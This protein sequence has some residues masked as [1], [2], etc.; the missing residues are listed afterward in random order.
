MASPMRRL[1][2]WWKPVLISALL[3]AVVCLVTSAASRSALMGDLERWGY[4]L[5]VNAGGYAPP[6]E[7]V[8]LV[9]FDD[10]SVAALHTFPVPRGLVAKTLRKVSEG[11]P[12]LI[13]LDML[14][15]EKR[16]PEE[17][18]E[19]A[20][21]LRGAGNVIL[22][23]QLSSGQL[24]LAGPMPEFC[25]PESD[26]KNISYCQ[27]GGAFGYASINMPVDDDGFIR[28]M[29]L[30]PPRGVSALPFPVAL[31]RDFRRLSLQAG[32][33]GV[34]RLG[35]HEIRLDDSGLNAALIGAWN[36]RPA[37]TVPAAAVLAPGFDPGV[38]KGKLV[39]I[40]QS[41]AAGADRHFTPVFRPR[42]QDGSRV[43]LSG[44]EIH[45]A[46]IATLLDARAVRVIDQ[47][48]LWAANFLAGL[49][50][51]V[52]IIVLRPV[53]SAPL[54][55]A[56][57]LGAYAAAQHL[58]SSHQAWMKFGTT[59]ATLLLALPAGLGYRFV[60]ERWLKSQAEAERQQ[61][62]GI[63]SRYVS[64]EVAAE[65]WE[66]RGEIVLGGQEKTAT[67]L[68]SDIRS[69]TALTAGKPSAEVLGWL[70]DYFTAMAE[71]IREQGGFLNK[72]IGD[73][74]MAV[75]GVPLSNGAQDDACRAVETALRMTARVE[76]LNREHE[77]DPRYPRIRIGVGVHTG[78][79]T[80]G[81]VGSRDRMEYSVIGETVNLASRLESLCK[82]FKID[83]VLSPETFALVQE[84]FAARP[85]GE[86]AVRGFEGKTQVYTVVRPSPVSG[87]TP[88]EQ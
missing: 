80:A 34:Y 19:M 4:D 47:Q 27:P 76:A 69:F 67:V 65:I 71:E 81:N 40:G 22:A 25:Q 85:L 84:R 45:A 66:R 23:S 86:T 10:A 54:T 73:G 29:Y 88:P 21:A 28:R 59:E 68:F 57:M 16:T 83:I 14:L 8:I 15:S 87:D 3:S 63:F 74:I 75:Y 24:P 61:L 77:D 32:A 60:Q 53:Y 20:A 13:G 58:F 51:L 39:L 1:A 44:A 33:A 78:P 41:N 64:P 50:L 38:F 56:A 36:T 37:R 43:M 79:L 52:L 62:M 55:L 17:D 30:L 35:P 26:P 12:E 70:N 72:F 18:Q 42:Q 5:L 31:A 2:T 49:L 9:D 82:D 46:A 11:N 7:D 48:T 6:R